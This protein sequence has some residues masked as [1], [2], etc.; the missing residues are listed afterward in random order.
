MAGD[1]FQLGNASWKICR[2]SSPAPSASRMLTASRRAF[3]SGSAKRRRER[4]NCRSAVA[5]FARKF[6]QDAGTQ[7]LRDAR[8]SRL[9]DWFMVETGVPE[10][11]CASNWPITSPR[12]IKPSVPC[13]RKTRSFMERFFDESGGMQFVI[14][15]PFGARLNRAWGLALRKR[16]CRSF[17]FELQ[18]AATDD[19]IVLSL[20]TQHSF[21]LDEV[22]HYLNSRDCP[23]D[24]RAG[25]ARCADVSAFAG[26][27]MRLARSRLPRQRRRTQDSPRRC[28]GWNR[29]I[30]WPPSF[31]TSSR[32]RKTLS[33]DR[34][35][36]DHPLVKQTIDD[37]LTEAMDIEGSRRSCAGLKRARFG[38]SRAI[39]PSLRRW[40]T[41]FSMRGLT[42]FSTMRRWRNGARRRFI[43]GAPATPPPMQTAWES[44]TLQ[45]SNGF[46]TMPGHG[47]QRR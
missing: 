19:A 18:S 13:R 6:D 21:P 23:R 41:R 32:A 3:R 33:G 27:G 20:G 2:R 24:S 7:R 25:V 38:A 26:V 9:A 35:V 29:K 47:N 30:C 42:L 11:G 14:H 46:A 1:I 39:C 8:L 36:P 34:V 17:N 12:P 45:R 37:C 28:N 22:F 43:R 40:R 15:S 4:R 5:R 31:P 10:A 16:F 44:L